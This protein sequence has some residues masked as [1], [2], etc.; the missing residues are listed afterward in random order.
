MSQYDLNLDDLPD[1]P[2]AQELRRGVSTYPFAPAVE[3]E[4][5]RSHLMRVRLRVRVWFSLMAGVAIGI[6]L[7]NAGQFGF[8]SWRSIMH[9]CFL[10]PLA[11]V[12]MAVAWSHLY[13]KWFLP[14]VHVLAPLNFAAA[15]VVVAQEVAA[16]RTDAMA[17]LVLQVVAAYFFVGLFFSRAVLSAG[18]V[19]VTYLLASMQLGIP[20]ENF[21]SSLVVLLITA[22]IGAFIQR[23]IEISYRRNFLEGLLVRT[24]VGRDGLT[25]LANRRAFDEHLPRVWQQGLRDRRSL[26]LGM[27]D[28]DHF[29]AYNDRYGHQAGDEALRAVTRAIQQFARRPLD[30]AAR[31]GGEEFAIILYDLPQPQLLLFAEQLRAAIE[32]L[33][34]PHDTA[35]GKYVTVSIGIGIVE[36]ALDR[37]THGAIQFADEALYEAKQA[38]RNRVVI[39]DG[40][41]YGATRTGTFARVST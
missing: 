2:Y 27:I 4:Y 31:Y 23:D 32:A 29:K 8:L 7:M 16:G 30:L 1:S 24:L 40:E 10:I 19:I 13:E 25:G 14:L 12:T 38:G 9:F 21:I 22:V 34:I 39:R 6:A 17:G 5:L 18:I 33:R 26:A 15:A 37:T 3:A 28:I 20:V 41:E 35:D 11:L 36:P